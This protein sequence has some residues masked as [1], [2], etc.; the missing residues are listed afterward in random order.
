MAASGSG[1][2][3]GRGAKAQAADQIRQAVQSTSNLFH[4]LQDSSTSQVSG[5]SMYSLDC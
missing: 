5:W 3:V 1:E 2:V 4:L